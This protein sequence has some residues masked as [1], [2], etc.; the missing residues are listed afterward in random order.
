MHVFIA[1]NR[2]AYIQRNLLQTYKK[3]RIPNHTHTHTHIAKYMH[4]YNLKK[5]T[6]LPIAMCTATT[7]QTYKQ[8]QTVVARV[9][10]GLRLLRRT[11]A[12]KL[13]RIVGLACTEFR[14]PT[15]T[16]GKRNKSTCKYK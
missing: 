2:F 1:T 11:T 15:R 14:L 10:A 6:Y 3:K 8:A 7:A 4:K 5:N 13:H 16:T 9:S 12:E